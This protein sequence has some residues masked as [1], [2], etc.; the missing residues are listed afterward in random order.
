MKIYIYNENCTRAGQV[1]IETRNMS[2]EDFAECGDLSLYGEGTRDE[3]IASAIESLATRY[4]KRCGGPGDAFRWKC[5]RN[6]LESLGGPEVQ[7]N[8]ETMT[9][10]PVL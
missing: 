3:L 10:E 1:A 2:E 8:L 5:D 4:D 7:F 6:V 9:Y